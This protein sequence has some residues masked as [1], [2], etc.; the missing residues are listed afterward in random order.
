M[1]PTHEHQRPRRRPT[2]GQS[3]L[4][5]QSASSII[6][7]ANAV[8]ALPAVLGPTTVAISAT[9][10]L[11]TRGSRG[12][13][14]AK[15]SA[16]VI[17][18]KYIRVRQNKWMHIGFECFLNLPFSQFILSSTSAFMTP[19]IT[20]AT[21]PVCPK[22]GTIRKSGKYS[23]CAPNGAWAKICGNPGDS[24]FAHTWTEGLQTCESKLVGN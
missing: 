2:Q 19:R 24:K 13:G 5:A 14:P 6:S 15:V 22:C 23:C 20:T 11:S 12:S 3:V 21:S 4:H 16:W 7:P 1:Y 8:V 17:K 9:H 18:C 10:S